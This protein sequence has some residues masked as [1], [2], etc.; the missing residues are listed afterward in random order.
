MQNSGS[1]P[2]DPGSSKFS[3]RNLRNGGKNRKLTQAQRLEY[4]SCYALFERDCLELNFNA[5]IATLRKIRQCF[6]D[7]DGTHGDYWA[8]SEELEG[9]LLDELKGKFFLSLNLNETEYYTNFRQKWIEVIKA[10][11]ASVGDIEEAWKCFALGRYAASVFHSLQVVEIGIIELGKAVGAIDHQSGWN[12]TTKA[13]ESTMKKKHQD[14]S[15]F[16]RLHFGFYEQIYATIEG[17]KNACRNKVSHAHNKWVVMTSDF[18]P[19]VGEEILFAPRAFMRRLATDAP[20]PEMAL[21]A[22]PHPA[23]QSP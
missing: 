8:Y 22:S 19:D 21:S 15:E 9:R 18:S 4:D 14:R 2:T 6:A 5:T 13:L 7:A 20:T 17:L 3:I 11:P 16:E 12:V 1:F 10:I 23:E